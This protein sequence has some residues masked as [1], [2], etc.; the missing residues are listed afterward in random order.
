MGEPQY[1]DV[2]FISRPDN[3]AVHSAIYLADNVV[4]TKNSGHYNQPWMLMTL[5]E[6]VAEYGA[7]M[8]ENEDPKVLFFRNRNY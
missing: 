2:V 1:G 6:L 8:E 7:I 3:I 5:D 4:F